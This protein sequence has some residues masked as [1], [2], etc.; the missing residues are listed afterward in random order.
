MLIRDLLQ[1]R[2]LRVVS[3]KASDKLFQRELRYAQRTTQ[4]DASLK[5]I[6]IAFDICLGKF[7]LVNNSS[8]PVIKQLAEFGEL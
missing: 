6:F 3:D 4:R 5:R 7:H 2:N 8:C 1:N